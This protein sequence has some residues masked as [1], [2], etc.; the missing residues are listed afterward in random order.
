MDRIFYNTYYTAETN[1]PKVETTKRTDNTDDA[2]T[3]QGVSDLHNIKRNNQ[4]HG[5]L[6]NGINGPRKFQWVHC[7]LGDEFK[8]F[9]DWYFSDIRFK[10]CYLFFS[11]EPHFGRFY[12]YNVY[13]G[14]IS[15]L[16]CERYFQ[17]P[18]QGFPRP[19][20]C[21]AQLLKSTTS[22]DLYVKSSEI[23]FIKDWLYPQ[24]IL[25]KSFA[26]LSIPA[27]IK[28]GTESQDVQVPK[29]E[30]TEFNELLGSFRRKGKIHDIFLKYYAWKKLLDKEDILIISFY[31]NY[32]VLNQTLYLA[33]PK[34]GVYSLG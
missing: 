29:P 25:N 26:E 2:K 33:S 13:T 24:R 4:K 27:Q 16:P 30:N 18:T 11:D 19:S 9:V 3:V 15:K 22:N 14:E 5:L 31:N 17:S 10:D 8:A 1:F 20:G 12:R 7:D 32:V 6:L 23:D 34:S 28:N 21:P